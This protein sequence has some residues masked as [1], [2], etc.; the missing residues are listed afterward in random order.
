MDKPG[1]IYQFL[2]G[3]MKQEHFEDIVRSGSVRIERIVSQGHSSSENEW[4]DQEENEWVMVIQGAGKIKYEDGVEILLQKGE[5]V[6]IPKH[7][8]HRVSWTDPNQ[9]TI[10]LAVFYS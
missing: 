6:T 8:R 3:N 1:N 4:Y 7:V 9:K 5:Y 10:W 2:P